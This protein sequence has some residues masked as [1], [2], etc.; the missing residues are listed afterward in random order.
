[1][2]YGHKGNATDNAFTTFNGQPTRTFYAF[3]TKTEREEAQEK[4]WQESGQSENLIFCTRKMVVENLGKDFVV[5]ADGRCMDEEG[6][7]AYMAEQEYLAQEG[8]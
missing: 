1:M 3:D 5:L 4:I 8:Q 7:D 6:Y 2:F